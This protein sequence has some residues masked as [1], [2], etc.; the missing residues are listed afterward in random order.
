MSANRTPRLSQLVNAST[1]DPAEAEKAVLREQI[2]AALAGLVTEAKCVPDDQEDMQEEKMI[3]LRRWEEKMAALMPLVEQG[4]MLGV[5]VWVDTADAPIVSQSVD[6]WYK[7]NK[8]N[9][10]DK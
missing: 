10:K 9:T 6:C 2:A 5:S 4:K 1:P 3:W 8:S 7:P